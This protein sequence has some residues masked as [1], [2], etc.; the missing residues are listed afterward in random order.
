MP[1]Q[2]TEDKAKTSSRLYGKA[3]TEL[4]RRHAEEFTEILAEA[5]AA[6]G[7]TYTPKMTKEEREARLE[8]ERKAKA[9]KTV[10]E[11]VSKYGA[12]IVPTP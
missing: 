3:T 5:Y 7:L 9:A 10:A 8:A 11:L 6:E 12:D 4:R 1:D 2:T